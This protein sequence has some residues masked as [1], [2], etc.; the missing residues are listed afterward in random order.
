MTE[1][2][3][4]RGFH[5]PSNDEAI[6][7]IHNE[8][9]ALWHDA[10][11]V[12]DMDRMTF[13]TAVIEAAANIVQHALPVAEKPVEID[14]DISV[15]TSRLVARVSA[16][17]AREPFAG[18]MQASMPDEDAESGRGLA[19]IEALV[20]TV[21]FERQDGTNTWILTRNT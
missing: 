17:N 4:H 3:A 9:D 21:T 2:I 11:F 14:V 8:L 12:P 7:A 20:T 18:D 16:F 5:G 13:A 15:R 6:E 10:S 1:V 19:L